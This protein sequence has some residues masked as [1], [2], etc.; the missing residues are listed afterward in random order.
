MVR[1]KTNYFLVRAT[2]L[3]MLGRVG[4]DS[5]FLHFFPSP[6]KSSRNCENRLNGISTQDTN[7]EGDLPKIEREAYEKG[8]MTFRNWTDTLTEGVFEDRIKCDNCGWSWKIK[9]GGFC[10]RVWS[11]SAGRGK[12]LGTKIIGN[13]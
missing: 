11:D 1:V 13:S 10:R 9:D 7:E 2:F 4:I 3:K 8:N 6:K 12:I 5:L